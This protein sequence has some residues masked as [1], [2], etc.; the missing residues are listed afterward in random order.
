[1]STDVVALLDELAEIQAQADL[2]RLDRQ[3]A[4]DGVITP[5][6]KAQIAEIE[7]EYTPTLT[8]ATDK[9]TDLEKRIKANVKELGESVKGTRLQAVFSTRTSWDTKALNG[10][11]AAHPEIE[12]F[13]K[14]SQSVSL[15]KVNGN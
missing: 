8:A 7:A 9:A 10:Y 6:I 13:R 12:Q 4:I 11:A 5:E 14:I 15:R 2:L 1:M 3:A